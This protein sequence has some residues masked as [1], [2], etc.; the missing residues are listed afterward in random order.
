MQRPVIQLNRQ[1]ASLQK[2]LTT[3]TDEL[4]KGNL[5]LVG[6]EL[7]ALEDHA[8]PVLVEMETLLCKV[9]ATIEKHQGIP[10]EIETSRG[11]VATPKVV[12]DG[13]LKP[14]VS[15]F[16]LSEL[17]ARMPDGTKILKVVYTLLRAIGKLGEAGERGDLSLDCLGNAVNRMITPEQGDD[18]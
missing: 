11:V 15:L 12:L 17:K 16:G 13:E 18:S 6:Q 1:I 5:E 4:K 14:V 7:D 8:S 10:I 2:R 3:L 9:N